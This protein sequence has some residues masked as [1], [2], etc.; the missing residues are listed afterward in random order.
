[1]SHRSIQHNLVPTSNP[2]DNDARYRA[3]DGTL[4]DRRLMALRG[5]LA[6]VGLTI[7]SA[8]IR[9]RSGRVHLTPTA[10]DDGAR[11]LISFTPTGPASDQPSRSDAAALSS[12]MEL[13]TSGARRTSSIHS[14]PAIAVGKPHVVM[15]STAT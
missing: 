15:A 6:V 2:S 1:M 7:A 4:G 14:A 13:S 10:H 3:A 12:P 5:G 11:P 9:Q 8:R